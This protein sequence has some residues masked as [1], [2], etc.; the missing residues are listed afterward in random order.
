MIE[1]ALESAAAR[2][3]EAVFGFR[4]AAFKGFRAGDILR[5]LE[6]ARVHADVAVGGLEQ[7]LEI[8]ESE[9]FVDSQRAHD[10][11]SHPLM[12]ELVEIG[13]AGLSAADAVRS[14]GLILPQSDR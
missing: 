2:R 14:R 1:I 8:V 10:A 6:L 5:V 7:L 3:C 13:W 9:R 12:D 11:E 4:H